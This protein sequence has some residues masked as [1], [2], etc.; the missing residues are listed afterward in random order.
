LSSV[1][2]SQKKLPPGQ[3]AIKRIL[4][5][6]IDHPG[7]TSDNPHLKLE[8]YSLT[9]DGEVE[10]PVKLNWNEFLQLP[11]AVSVSD[12][13]CVE[14]WSVLDCQWEGVHIK[15]LERLV[16]PKDVAKAV[17]FEC[18]DDILPRSSGRNL[19]AT[20]W[21]WLTSSTTN[22]WRKATASPCG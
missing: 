8:T 22:H 18:A 6:G 14:G 16:K 21:P 19:Q 12:F 4:R 3:N 1:N 7:I 2:N 9:I 11:Q 20:V 10:K 15:E 17:M 5:W 13:H